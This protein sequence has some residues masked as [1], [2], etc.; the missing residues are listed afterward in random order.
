MTERKR[1]MRVEVKSISTLRPYVNNPRTHSKRQIGEIAASIKEFGWTNPILIDDADNI[2]AG[3]G[4]LE[5]AKSLGLERVPT[6]RLTDLS[7]A[8]IRAYIIADNKLAEN[9]GWDKELLALELGELMEIEFDVKLTGF[10]TA[11]IDILFEE[12]NF[13]S[14]D[15]ADEIPGLNTDHDPITQAGDLWL[16]G[17]HRLLC[18]D[19]MDAHSY[20]RLLDGKSAQ[21]I[22]A[23]VPYNVPIA[24]HVSGLGRTQHH[25]FEIASGEM[26]SEEFTK[27]LGRVF[28]HMAFFSTEG[29]IHF[30]C[31]D[32]R[33]LMELLEAGDRSYTELK[34]L[35]VWNKTNGGM[36]SLYRSKHELVFVFKNGKAPHINNVELGKHGRNRSNVWEYA[37]VNAFGASRD[38][39]LAMHPTVKPVAMVADAIRDC[40]KRGGLI[41]DPFVG[42]GTTIIAAEQT[43]RIAAALEI[44]PHYVDVAI[45]RWQRVTGD[46][47]IHHETRLTF[48]ERRSRKKDDA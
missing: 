46:K 32:W 48:D 11:E 45:E 9:A 33:H 13:D 23:D 37:G 20:L 2:I 31:M 3:H 16:L 27:F 40:S 25:E 8:Q 12:I 14:V 39:D 5:A 36:G 38:E 7:D 17:S 41:L 35:C 28:D 44:D 19:A 6:I 4:R 29:S 15:H 22:F 1:D 24:G 34:A 21:M 10:K 30:I 43:G 47:A 18:A 42:S 26:T